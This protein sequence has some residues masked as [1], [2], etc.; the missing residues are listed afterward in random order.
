MSPCARVQA[1]I[2]GYVK[3]DFASEDDFIDHLSDEV[4]KSD[5]AVKKIRNC[6][7]ALR[8][9]SNRALE[10]QL[11]KAETKAT[12]L[13]QDTLA[14]IKSA[15]KKPGLA[16]IEENDEFLEIKASFKKVVRTLNV[17][18][19]DIQ[20]LSVQVSYD[21]AGSAE[22]IETQDAGYNEGPVDSG[23]LELEMV[24]NSE[25]IDI[26]KE[27]EAENRQDAMQLAQ[28]TVV[29]RDMM[30]DTVTLIE[31]QGEQLQEV[32]ETVETAAETTE[33]A[34]KELEAARGHQKATQKIKIIIGSVCACLVLTGIIIIAVHFGSDSS[35]FEPAPDATTTT[36]PPPSGSGSGSG[37]GTGA[38]TGSGSGD[39]NVAS[40]LLRAAVDDL[41]EAYAR[42]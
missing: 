32:D 39:S 12:A 36:A 1:N 11:K 3:M 42:R 14:L 7:R 2:S 22:N 13:V 20:Q 38:G 31:E 29:L 10:E 24:F 17:C 40:R 33:Q 8:A 21:N 26:D 18:L 27:I 16:R 19:Q 41:R 37:T 6:L 4:E 34:V 30:Q 9:Q 15:P 23:D 25:Q 28:D 35:P 5:K